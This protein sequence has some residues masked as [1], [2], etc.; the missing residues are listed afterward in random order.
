MRR[1][2]H[3]DLAAEL[4]DLF[5][6]EGG[7]DQRRPGLP[8]RAAALPPP[9]QPRAAR[10]APPPALPAQFGGGGG[11]LLS[12]PG[13]VRDPPA[14]PSLAEGPRTGRADPGTTAS[15]ERAGA[16]QQAAAL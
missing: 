11:A 5:P 14:P 10:R 7:R 6:R 4:A 15:N 1:P 9:G 3:R 8:P 2:A 13:R 16:G 12:L